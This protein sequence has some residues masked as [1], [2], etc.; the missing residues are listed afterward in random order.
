MIIVDTSVLIDFLRGEDLPG[1]AR[2]RRLEE[3]AI[4]FAV[5]AVC[6]QEVLQGAKNE[7]EWR[8]LG[9]YLG[10][11]RLLVPLEPWSTH[12]EAARIYFDC[13]RQG[14]TVR[15]SIDC[16]IAQLALEE[17]GVLLHNDRD[18]ETI[19]QVRPLRT[20]RS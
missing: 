15:S 16:Y 8:L 10:S 7:K 9:D 18:F 1:A 5:P 4:P 12:R 14:L 3:E 20:M 2:L 6:C 13:R 19:Q 11:Q 17:D